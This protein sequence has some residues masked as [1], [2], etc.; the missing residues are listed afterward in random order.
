[1]HR[2]GETAYHQDFMNVKSHFAHVG[3]LQKA[4][5]EDVNVAEISK[6]YARKLSLIRKIRQIKQKSF[7][8]EKEQA[9]RMSK[10]LEN[11]K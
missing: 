8:K 6:N 10:L 11:N 7:K 3:A 5:D 2:G 4:L 1:M 9:I